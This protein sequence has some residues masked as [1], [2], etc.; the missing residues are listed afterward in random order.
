MFKRFWHTAKKP[1]WRMVK[2]INVSA[3]GVAV[4]LFVFQ[5]I[6]VLTGLFSVG[7]E[8][9]L[10]LFPAF[11][12]SYLTT[13]QLL[14][15]FLTPFVLLYAGVKLFFMTL[16]PSRVLKQKESREATEKNRETKEVKKAKET[17]EETTPPIHGPIQQQKE[18]IQTQ[19]IHILHANKEALD[20][21]EIH[22]LER[23]HQELLTKATDSYMNLSETDQRKYES[24]VLKRFAELAET[25]QS[26]A[27]KGNRQ[28]E[29]D[30]QKHLH[31]IDETTK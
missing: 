20:I 5:A 15:V 4:L 21:E 8:T 14:A 3:I 31:I 13:F 16:F 9:F 25:V 30:L 17:K 27:Q 28:R 11:F 2:A 22:L 12:T 7:P 6:N 1:L 18:V 26:I 23:I 29:Q 10:G 19:I 24:E